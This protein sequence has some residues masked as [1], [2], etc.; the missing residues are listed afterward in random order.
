MKKLTLDEVKK[1]QLEILAYIDSFCKKNNI[2][3]F[4]NYGTLLG[5]VRHKGFIPWDDDIDISMDREY[6]NMFIEKFNQDSSK[7]KILS[8]DTDKAYFNNFIKVV[9]TTTKIVDN[10]N[11]KTFSC[12]VFV[13]IFPM[14]KFNDKKIINTCYILESLKLLSFSKRKN[15]IYKDSIVK[16]IIRS[17]FWGL[18]LPV[19]P[20]LFANIIERK[21]IQD[22]DRNGKYTAFIPSKLKEKEI[23]NAQIFNEFI[24][25]EF[26]HLTL[27]APKNYDVILTQYYGNYLELPPKEK[28]INIHE[29]EAYKIVAEGLKGY[30]VTIRT[31]DI[32]GDKSLPYME[33]P[34]EENPFLGWRAIRVC[35]DRQEIL[36]T[37]FR[38]LLRAS[39]YGQIKIML[40]MIMDIEEIRKAKAIFE[41]CKKELREEGIEFD[42]KIMLGIMVETPAVAFRAKYFAKE[43]DFFSIGTN[44]LTQYTLAVDRGNEKIANLYDTYNP[45]VLQAI[46][47]LIDGAHEGGIKISMCGEFAGD[48]NAVA[49]LFGMGLDAFSM[50]GIS[51]PRVK[52]IIMK[53]DKK[54]CQ[55]LV[56]R[57]LSL[58]TASEIKEEVKKFMEKI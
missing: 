56:E 6:Y 43:C 36:K 21:I 47:M 51:I 1:I 19:S 44:D 53:L 26:E 5:A 48:E 49:L 32:G 17:S 39:K 15:I 57:V 20:R 58:S 9:D 11:Y 46:K 2:S 7:Y 14:D 24:D 25:M 54:E 8:L 18:F 55:N 13:D 10:R 4:I 16:D 45:A 50:S 41:N 38:A 28:Q 34:Q 35:L 31:M 27:P 30:P 29:F 37:Q 22:T 40:P 42:E 12:G 33:L 52:R 23:F 3:Y